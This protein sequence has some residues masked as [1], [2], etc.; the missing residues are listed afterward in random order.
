MATVIHTMTPW[1][2]DTHF[3]ASPSISVSVPKKRR[4]SVSPA[5]GPVPVTTVPASTAIQVDA[6]QPHHSPPHARHD[7]GHPPAAVGLVRASQHHHRRPDEHHREQEVQLHDGGMQV[8]PHHDG[9]HQTLHRHA[10]QHD[11]ASSRGGRADGVCGTRLPLR[12]VPHRC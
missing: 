4:A 5:C 1:M 8:G 3:S 6:H 11:H 10:E 2:R 9:A 7:R 12:R